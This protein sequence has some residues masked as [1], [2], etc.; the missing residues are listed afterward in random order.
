MNETTHLPD[1]A[2]RRIYANGTFTQEV[3]TAVEGDGPLAPEGGLLVAFARFLEAPHAFAGLDRRVGVLIGPADD[4]ARLA[5]HL[6]GLDLVVVDFPKFSDGRGFSSARIL[7]E[8]LGYVGDIRAAGAY[9]LDQMPL[10]RRCGVTSFEIVKP[11]IEKALAVGHWPE[12]TRY[13]QPVGTVAERPAGTRPWA[14]LPASAVPEAA[15]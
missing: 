4:V 6:A 5:G 11:E 1:A 7:R 15:E 9:I 3:W 12:V 8:Q 13:L 2:L 10:L 14:R